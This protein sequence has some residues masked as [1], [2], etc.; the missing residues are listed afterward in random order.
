M[1]P[2]ARRPTPIRPAGHAI[3]TVERRSG[4]HWL[5]NSLIGLLSIVIIVVCAVFFWISW[6]LNVPVGGGAQVVDIK[7]NT[8][9][10]DIAKQLKQVGLIRDEAIFSVYSKLGPARGILKPG[11][12]QLKGSMSMVQIVDYISAGKIAVVNFVVKDGSTMTEIA[13][14]YAAQGLGSSQEFK[15]ALAAAQLPVAVQARFGAP[16]TLEG[17][18]LADTYQV[19]IND[20]AFMVVQ[21]L[22]ANFETKALPLFSANLPG[23]LT[24]NQTLTL[25][26]IVE[27]EASLPADRA[28]VADVFYNR[29]RLGMKLE[30]DV[31]VIYLTGRREPTAADL[32]IDSPY[33]TRR[34]AG[35][36][37]G[38]INSPSIGSIVA[39][40]QPAKTANLFFIGG[41]DGKVYY[42]QTYAEHNENIRKYIK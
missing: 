34:Y 17:F 18:L 21:K 26:S 4:K 32:R 39:T 41:T 2:Q 3:Q 29:L 36:P 38:P 8:S 15:E 6:N 22:L 30:S 16:K 42:A 24:P 19:V 27:K 5:R 13:D 37:P 25:A 14:S 31:T 12:Y 23:N 7:P 11:P 20:S 40:I 1:T 35:L 33:N 10:S 28:G 9:I